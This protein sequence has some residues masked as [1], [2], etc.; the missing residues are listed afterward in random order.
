MDRVDDREPRRD[1]EPDVAPEYAGEKTFIDEVRDGPG[2][3]RVAE[4]P[5]DD[6]L[7]S[8]RAGATPDR[9]IVGEEL[10][11]P[12]PPGGYHDSPN[13]EI[14]GEGVG[15]VGG[16]VAGAA[17]GSLAGPIG[18]V[19]GGIAGAIGGWWAGKEVTETI[20][21]VRPEEETA[22]REHY[23]TPDNG[24]A[25]RRYEDVH[26]LYALGYAAGANPAYA[27]RSFEEIEPELRQGWTPT[28]AATHGEWIVV[29]RYA[30]EGYLRWRDRHERVGGTPRAMSPAEEALDRLHRDNTTL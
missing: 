22:F 7:P 5:V 20:G 30:R 19:I 2:P 11:P 17:I 8:E 10:A 23:E 25:D 21:G 24:I 26:P 16:A 9:D 14:V 1:D 4:R 12:E 27:N 29:R 6:A 18:T 3:D 15:G 13:A 28:L